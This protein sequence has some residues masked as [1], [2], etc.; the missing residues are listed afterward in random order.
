VIM[1]LKPPTTLSDAAGRL[2]RLVASVKQTQ[3]ESTG[4]K[5]QPQPLPAQTDPEEEWARQFGTRIFTPGGEKSGPAPWQRLARRPQDGSG[6]M[7][8]PAPVRLAVVEP[9]AKRAEI[10]PKP[11]TESHI[12]AGLGKPGRNKGFLGRLFHPS[13]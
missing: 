5:G 13:R 8:R 10:A 12:G 6:K 3:F 2:D 1:A 11:V 9:E 4:L 7:L